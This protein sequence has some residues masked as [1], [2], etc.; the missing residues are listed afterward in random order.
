[1]SSNDIQTW[2]R[3]NI[4]TS[5]Y[6]Y[7]IAYGADKYIAVGDYGTLISSSDG[8]N[9][10]VQKALS[11]I[12]ATYITYAKNI[13]L[14]VGTDGALFISNNGINW[15]P[16]NSLTSK[17]LFFA[18][19]VQGKFF[20]SGEDGFIGYSTDG[21]DWNAATTNLQKETIV[22]IVSDGTKF[23][24]FS[25]SGKVLVS[26][27]GITWSASFDLG[28][29]TTVNSA[30]YNNGYFI[31]VGIKIDYTTK[32]IPAHYNIFRSKDGKNWEFVP[33]VNKN[34]INIV[35]YDGNYIL[36]IP[37]GIRYSNNMVNWSSAFMGSRCTIQ[38]L[39][40]VN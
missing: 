25:S 6:L 21:V 11:M 16:L 37:G 27:D 40:R 34:S 20:I 5:N 28:A 2:N 39:V 7:G 31:A 9:W 26:N 38:S 18:G 4:P 12:Q 8:I 1:M 10:T 29:N 15:L 35:A 32:P 36:T 23:L 13:F 22:S 3:V 14:V 33:V 24:A 17:G 30:I 19:F